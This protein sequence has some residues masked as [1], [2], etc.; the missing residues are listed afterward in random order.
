ML[1]VYVHLDVRGLPRDMIYD[2]E[3]VEAVWRELPDAG[4]G[5]RRGG[6]GITLSQYALNA[7][8]AALR[9]TDRVRRALAAIGWADAIV[10]VDEVIREGVR[11][12]ISCLVHA[13]RWHFSS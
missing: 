8:A 3:F 10:E 4:L 7:D 2:D 6:I 13:I 9:Q 11:D 5:G 12:D 1:N